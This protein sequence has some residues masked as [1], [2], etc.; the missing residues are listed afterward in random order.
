MSKLDSFRFIEP[1][2]EIY[3]NVRQGIFQF[4]GKINPHYIL[5]TIRVEKLLKYYSEMTGNDNITIHGKFLHGMFCLMIT[6]FG[7]KYYD[8]KISGYLNYHNNISLN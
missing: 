6:L 7:N 2:H 8:R 5:E 1:N 3:M 4:D